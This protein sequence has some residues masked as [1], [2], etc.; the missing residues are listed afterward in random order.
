M[1]PAILHPP[2]WAPKG[3]CTVLLLSLYKHYILTTHLSKIELTKHTKEK[4][5]K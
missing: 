2:P 5:I 3:V 4:D 1:E